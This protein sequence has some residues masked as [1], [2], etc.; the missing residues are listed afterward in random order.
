MNI[1]PIP[2]LRYLYFIAVSS[3]WTINPKTPISVLG[4]VFQMDNFYFLKKHKNNPS[5]ENDF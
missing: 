5:I 4:F 3:L 2:L 1:L